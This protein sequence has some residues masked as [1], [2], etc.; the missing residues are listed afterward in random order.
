MKISWETDAPK[1]VKG[2]NEIVRYAH[3]MFYSCFS[4]IL[5]SIAALLSNILAVETAVI[6]PES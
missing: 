1:K 4:K 3:Q 6:N 5:N 2:L